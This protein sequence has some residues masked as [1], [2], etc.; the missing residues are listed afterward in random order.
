MVGKE[1]LFIENNEI[2]L[3]AEYYE[4]SSKKDIAIIICHPH[5]QFLGV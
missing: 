4:S 2:K 5:P 3:E 1:N